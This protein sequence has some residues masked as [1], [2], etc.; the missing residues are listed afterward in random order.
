MIYIW[1]YHIENPMDCSH[2]RI[3]S[4]I[5]MAIL[6]HANNLPLNLQMGNLLLGTIINILTA[7]VQMFYKS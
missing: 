7:M 6:N 5:K 2:A 1:N 3:T 4:T